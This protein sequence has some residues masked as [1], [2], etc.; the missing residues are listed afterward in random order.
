MKEEMPKKKTPVVWN[1]TMQKERN[2]SLF[3]VALFKNKEDLVVAGVGNALGVEDALPVA[4]LE[5][6]FRSEVDLSKNNNKNM[7]HHYHHHI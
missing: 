2:C 4:G 6:G 1:L 3:V 5:V 7:H